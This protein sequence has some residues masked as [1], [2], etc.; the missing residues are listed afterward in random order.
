M[1]DNPYYLVRVKEEFED[2]QSGKTKKVVRQKLVR[3][4][5]ITD[6]EAKVN[7]LYTSVTFDW[8]IIGSNVSS[9]DEVIE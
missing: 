5:S 3:A 7:K 2:P 9:I 1:N 8:E 6:S 4:V